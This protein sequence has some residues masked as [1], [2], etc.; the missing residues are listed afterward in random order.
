MDLI[1]GLV[2]PVNNPIQIPNSDMI[3]LLP[4]PDA[5]CAVREIIT[6]TGFVTD[7]VVNLAGAILN[8]KLSEEDRHCFSSFEQPEM[9]E[10]GSRETRSLEAERVFDPVLA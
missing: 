1:G 6:L 8:T 2:L 4:P 5:E 9:F 10:A 7:I 3:P